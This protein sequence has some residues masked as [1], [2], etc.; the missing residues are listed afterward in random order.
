MF[1][2]NCK[3]EFVG[4]KLYMLEKPFFIQAASILSCILANVKNID[5]LNNFYTSP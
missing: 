2:C 5:I 1:I 4:T 3:Q